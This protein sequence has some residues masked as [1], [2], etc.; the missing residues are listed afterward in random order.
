MANANDIDILVQLGFSADEA[1]LANTKTSLNAQAALIGELTNR[2]KVLNDQ[3]T[4]GAQRS[5]VEEAK[6]IQQFDKAKGSL[7]RIT[8]SYKTQQAAHAAFNTNLAKT[9][10]E[11]GRAD[12]ALINF[13]RIVQDAPYGFLGISNNLNPMLES[14]QRLQVE[15]GSAGGALKAMA[16][17]L[18]GAQ[19]LGIALSVVSSLL[20]VFGSKLFDTGKSA[21]DAKQTI[22][23]LTTSIKDQIKAYYDLTSQSDAKEEALRKEVELRKAAGVVNGNVAAADIEI[24]AKEQTAR[25]KKIADLKAQIALNDEINKAFSPT[26]T[27]YENRNATNYSKGQTAHDRA[28]DYISKNAGLVPAEIINAIKD[29]IQK[30]EK[31][32]G[33]F[34]DF[35]KKSNKEL[36]KDL[37]KQQDD[38][39]IA[40]L[41]LEAKFAQKRYEITKAL[42]NDLFGLDVDLINKQIEGQEQNA[43]I[44]LARQKTLA[45]AKVLLNQAT[46]TRDA[47]LAEQLAAKETTKS[48]EVADLDI[49]IQQKYNQK[50]ADINRI[51]KQELKNINDEF[52]QK[53]IEARKKYLEDIDNADKGQLQRELTLAQK[54]DEDTMNVRLRLLQDDAKETQKATQVKYDALFKEAEKAGIDTT[55]LQQIY[56]NE[57]AINEG[58]A[59]QKQLDALDAYYQDRIKIIGNKSDLEASKIKLANRDSNNLPVLLNQNKLLQ[60]KD[61]LG[62][63]QESY[64]RTLDNSILSEDEWAAAAEKAEKRVI[65][66]QNKVKDAQD[67]VLKSKVDVITNDISS[68]N[69]LAQSLGKSALE[70]IDIEKYKTDALITEQQRRVDAVTKIASEGNAE[71][72][73]QEQDRLDKL[74][75]AQAKHAQNERAINAVLIASQSALNIV[76]AIGAVI[77]ASDKKNVVSFVVSIIAAAAAVAAGIAATISAVSKQNSGG[78]Y[79]GGFTGDGKDHEEAG[80]VHKNE[81]VMDAKT[82]RKL[83]KGN[84]D[85][86]RRGE[87]TMAD[88]D[89]HGMH[90]DANYI[91]RSGI[92]RQYDMHRLESKMDLVAEEI[93]NKEVMGMTAD[94]NGFTIHSMRRQAHYNKMSKL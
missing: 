63:A 29:Q 16:S 1:A 40:K 57:I 18:T 92:E 91:R 38:A 60:A 55:R 62:Q 31:A 6:L 80:K 72:L 53:E 41:A 39:D 59:H 93:R 7:D 5:V 81:Y 20:V 43:N 69:D 88:V 11:T 21:E 10:Q 23:N 70:V 13:G 75:A 65:D 27:D 34:A 61:E 77:E 42:N 73:K 44:S 37:L 26:E 68:A 9:T 32:D 74:T 82:T 49:A 19:G 22:D 2:V 14:F 90:A 24:A 35:T 48:G 8:A 79:K 30:L 54:N 17:S 86:L 51:A 15:T 46:A 76:K 47:A 12:L 58:E 36:N 87:I 66:A 52:R 45:E 28:I 33:T 78:F 85:K 67:A 84:L 64:D 25:D 50:F 83:G 4:N 71:L 94:I 3:L 89:Y 56:N